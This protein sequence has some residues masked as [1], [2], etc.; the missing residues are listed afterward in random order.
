MHFTYFPFDKTKYFPLLKLN[1]NLTAVVGTA[2]SV[3]KK[4]F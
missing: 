4:D 3:I 2:T 1:V